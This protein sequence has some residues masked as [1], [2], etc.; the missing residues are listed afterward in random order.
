MDNE[1]LLIFADL[2]LI[3]HSSLVAFVILGLVAIYAGYFLEWQWI[4]N[5]WFRLTHLIVIAIHSLLQC[6]GM[7]VYPCL[8]GVRGAGSGELVRGAAKA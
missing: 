7:G 5:V 2:L 8:H 4:H 3:V 1:W 6:T